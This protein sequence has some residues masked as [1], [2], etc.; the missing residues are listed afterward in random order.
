MSLVESSFIGDNLIGFFFKSFQIY[1]STICLSGLQKK[2][3]LLFFLSLSSFSEMETQMIIWT[4]IWTVDTL[5]MK[6]LSILINQ[7]IC[8]RGLVGSRHSGK[9]NWIAAPTDYGRPMKPFLIEIQNFW[10][11]TNLILGHL[12]YFR[13]NYQHPFWKIFAFQT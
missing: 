7:F 11:W 9:L 12:G 10:A 2:T 6:F 1:F 5:F 4:I 3:S 13:P 8:L